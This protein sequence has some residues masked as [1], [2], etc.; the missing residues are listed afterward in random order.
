MVIRG[1]ARAIPGRVPESPGGLVAPGQQDEEEKRVLNGPAVGEP[2]AGTDAGEARVGAERPGDPAAVHGS[3]RQEI[4]EVDHQSEIGQGDEE[5]RI[6][7]VARQAHETSAQA[8]QDRPPKGN[9]RFLPGVPGELLGG[10]DSAHKRD[11][12][13]GRKG[14]APGVH[15]GG[16][17]N[18]VHQNQSDHARC[19]REAEKHGVGSDREDHAAQRGQL[20]QLESGQDVLG[21]AKED[22][23]TGSDHSGR[24]SEADIVVV[25]AL[26]FGIGGI[27]LAGKAREG[28]GGGS[29]G[30]GDGGGNR[31]PQRNRQRNRP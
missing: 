26:R 16:V 7:G 31:N 24:V 4:E 19:V 20:G 10:N 28:T 25:V 17:S 30:V 3:Q 1:H 9:E 8:S 23:G 6:G 21:L 15:H 11:K 22:Q 14:D 27:A 18:L 29:V 5:L 13:H 2:S 12:D